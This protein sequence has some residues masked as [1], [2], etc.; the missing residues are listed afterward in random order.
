MK[1]AVQAIE[2]KFF[3]Y[4]AKMKN[5]EE[6]LA[7]IGW[8]LRTGAPKKGIKQRSEVIGTLSEDVFNMSIS[9]EMKDYI[10]ALTDPSVQIYLTDVTKRSVE[11]CEKQY[12]QNINIPA[13]EYKDYV[14]LQ[15]QSE[16]IWE[17]AKATSDFARLQPY[18]EKLIAFKKRMVGYWGITENKYNALLDL[19]EPGVTVDIIDKVFGQLRESIVPLVREISATG[20]RPPFDFLF[21]HFPKPQQ[22]AFSHYILQQMG[23]DFE[24]GRLDETAHPFQT[25][26]NP[27]DVRVTT[28]YNESDFRLAIFGTIHE[29]GHALYEQNISHKLIGTPLCQGTSMGIHESQSLFFENLLGRSREFWESFYSPFKKYANGAFDRVSLD[30]F[31]RAINIAGP[32]LIRIEADELT[33]PLHI[34]VRYEIEKGLFNG[35]LKVKDLPGIWNEKMEE[36][37]GIRPSNDREGVLQDI[38]WAGGDFGYFPSYALGYVYAAQFKHAMLEDS[39]SLNKSLIEGDI[40][41]I[42]QWLTEHIHQYGALKKPIQIVQEATHESLNATYLIQYLTKKYRGIYRIE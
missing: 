1:Q 17:E 38:H 11:E 32:S 36:Y 33:Y 41:P 7:L 24:A 28:N 18:L 31:Y 6:A 13:N 26:L 27:A 5:Y 25:T 22:Q 23:F 40:A 9:T 21:C 42:R 15:S 14:I 20:S 30:D 35:D 10:E 2:K 34:I 4:I 19:Y 8:D 16:S 12:N 29:G 39:P 37:L 3:N